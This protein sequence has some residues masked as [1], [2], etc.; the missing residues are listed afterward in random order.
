[1]SPL[2]SFQGNNYNRFSDGHPGIAG[3]GGIRGIQGERGSKGAP[4]S[5]GP[6]GPP[7]LVGPPGSCSHCQVN[8]HKPH[9][10]ESPSHV[11]PSAIEHETSDLGYDEEVSNKPKS[12]PRQ[13][14]APARPSPAHKKHSARVRPTPAPAPPSPPSQYSVETDTT[15]APAPPAP[16][17]GAESVTQAP[18]RQ[19]T[20]EAPYQPPPTFTQAPVRSTTEEAPY[21]PPPTTPYSAPTTTTSRPAESSTSYNVA[22]EPTQ[23]VL[24]SYGDE[25]TEPVTPEPDQPKLPTGYSNDQL[26]IMSPARAYSQRIVKFDHPTVVRTKQ[27]RATM[28]NSFP[29]HMAPILSE[30]YGMPARPRSIT[31]PTTNNLP[32][33]LPGTSAGKAV[34]D[35]ASTSAVILWY[36]V[37]LNFVYMLYFISGRLG[38]ED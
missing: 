18:I 10:S 29:A 23:N 9:R 8:V 1:M 6:I 27:V 38:D 22:I 12:Q 11:P 28:C 24:P 14:S 20:E 32:H 15:Y 4:G 25:P 26:I 37:M 35:I 36:S 34:D 31:L 21:Q 17:Y 16:S 30:D 33:L 13:P 3:S 7:G 5:P 19:T 2:F